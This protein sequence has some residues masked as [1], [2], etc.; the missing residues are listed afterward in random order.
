MKILQITPYL[1]PK[2]GGQE[3]HVLA[4]SETLS[5]LGHDVTILT[6]GPFP[7]SIV[8]GFDVLKTSSVNFLGLR[9]ISVKELTHFLKENRF[10]VCHLH[11]QTILG[12]TILLINKIRKLPTV[13]TL[14][15]LMLRRIPAEFLYDGISLRFISALS[16]KVICLSSNI[17]Q[18]LVR[19]G[20]K[21]SKCVVIPNAINIQSFKDRFRKIGKE[22]REPKF[23]LL[24]V[25]RLE[26]R[27]GVNW[28]L[29]SLTLLHKKGKK[30]TLRI[31][32]HGPLTREL[33]EII[34]ANNLSQYVKLLGYVPQQ[35]LLKLYLLA[36][37]VVIP[38][39]YEGIPA[40]ALEAMAAG[41]PL[42]VSNV[43]GLNELVTNGSN[44]LKVNPMDT[45]GLASAID[46][47]LTSPNYL[48]SLD[49]VNEKVLA[50]FDWEVVANNVAKT[51]HES[52]GGSRYN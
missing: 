17:M 33:S 34:S 7:S 9:I 1:D 49:N 24:F 26:Q 28:L 29:K 31:V 27:K 36:K 6:C 19:R 38:S 18:N 12:E 25:G 30:S 52:L 23:D 47:I 39:L 10:E 48:S 13:T 4:L 15:S 3:K 8:Q 44:G 43:P 51:Y 35:E 45:Q 32:G 41:K 14:H 37:V 40:V 21:R 5:R 50:K 2:L 46:R 11:H 42:I 20:L 22:L 16:S